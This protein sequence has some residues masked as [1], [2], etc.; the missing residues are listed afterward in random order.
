MVHC[1]NFFRKS[2]TKRCAR[3]RTLIINKKTLTNKY[4]NLKINTMDFFLK[5][6]S[7][8]SIIIAS[9]KLAIMA[10]LTPGMVAFIIVC[11]LLIL[12]GNRTIYIITAAAAA[13]VLFI[14]V[15]GTGNVTAESFLLQGILT[16]AIVMFGLYIMIKSIVPSSQ[17]R[18]SS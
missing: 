9:I 12:I 4:H 17:K 11:G 7:I 5:F 18:K 6:C 2:P 3:W 8:I 13:L 10:S 15:Y 16:L 14:K 1:K